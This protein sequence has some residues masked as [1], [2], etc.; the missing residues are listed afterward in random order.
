MGKQGNIKESEQGVGVSGGN[1]VA[2]IDVQ[3]NELKEGG[4][5][6]KC[7]ASKGKHG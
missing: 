5:E 7:S 1:W 6:T 3:E 4:E 2:V